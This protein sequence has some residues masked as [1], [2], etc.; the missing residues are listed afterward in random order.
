[1]R[2]L[3]VIKNL[4]MAANDDE[5]KERQQQEEEEEEQEEEQE[6]PK[7]FMA[8]SVSSISSCFPT[9]TCSVVSLFSPSSSPAASIRTAVY[10]SIASLFNFPDYFGHNLD[11]LDECLNEFALAPS[12]ST[13]Y[14]INEFDAIYSQDSEF[15]E[16]LMAVLQDWIVAQEGGD[17]AVGLLLLSED[18]K[19]RL[20]FNGELFDLVYDEEPAI[21]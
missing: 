18:P 11:A 8:P 17:W 3:C 21:E 19:L 20:D 12:V 7:V 16:G 14:T 10:E 15:A 2:A 5:A 9:S 6:Q 13:L 1:M 4:L